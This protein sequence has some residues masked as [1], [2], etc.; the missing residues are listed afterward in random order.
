MT[1]ISI[2]ATHSHVKD[3]VRIQPRA[4]RNG[5]GPLL[6]CGFVSSVLYI[7]MNALSPLQWDSYSLASHTISELSAIDAPTRTLWVSWAVVY[8]LFLTAFG[9]GVYKT[10]GPRRSLRVVGVVLIGLFATILYRA[11]RRRW[12]RPRLA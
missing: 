1:T 7:A 10:A 3:P 9:W 4:W 2:P 8:S 11:I 12:L 6:L 5:H